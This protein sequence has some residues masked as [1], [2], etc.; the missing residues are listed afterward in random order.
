LSDFEGFE[1]GPAQLKKS[2]IEFEGGAGRKRS[3][4]DLDEE[5]GGGRGRKSTRNQAEK[6]QSCLE[7]IMSL[8]N[9]DKSGSRGNG[10]RTKFSE[11]TK[12]EQQE[13]INNLWNKARRYNNKLRF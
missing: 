2:S 12:E 6:K 11:M 1:F 10:D 9:S 13:R 7:K 8:G 5:F 4:R 3:D